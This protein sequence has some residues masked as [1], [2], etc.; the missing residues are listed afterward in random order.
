MERESDRRGCRGIK[1]AGFPRRLERGRRRTRQDQ[2][3]TLA[4]AR[5]K[6]AELK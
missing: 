5:V 1:K 2:I 6:T 3:P 4:E